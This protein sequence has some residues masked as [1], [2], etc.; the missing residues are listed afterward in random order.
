M[1]GPEAEARRPEM[2]VVVA[3]VVWW[4]GR[5]EVRQGVVVI[6]G[7]LISILKDSVFTH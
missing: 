5:D 2:G 4:W 7:G 3:A 6:V 1:R